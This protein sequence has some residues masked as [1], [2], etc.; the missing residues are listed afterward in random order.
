MATLLGVVTGA[1]PD[2]RGEPVAWV[3]PL[4]DVTDS[5]READPEE[6]PTRGYLFWPQAKDAVRDALVFVRPR[7]NSVHLPGLKDDYMVADPHLAIEVIDFRSM[8]NL[9]D[10]RVALTDGVKLSGVHVV[11]RVLLWCDGNICLGPVRL[12]SGPTGTTLEK[13][14]RHRIPTFRLKPE[15]IKVVKFE[16]ATRYVLSNTTLGGPDGYVDWDDDRQVVKRAIEYSIEVAKRDGAAVDRAKQLVEE[17]LKELQGRTSPADLRLELYRLERATPLL[18]NASHSKEVAAAF[19][20]SLRELPAIKQELDQ[21]K[22]EE[23]ELMRSQIDNAFKTERELLAKVKSER[24]SAES[25]LV[26]T[27]KEIAEREDE[28]KKTAIA[29]DE[30]IRKTIADAVNSAPAIL[31]QVALLKPFLEGGAERNALSEHS[32]ATKRT[33]YQLPWKLGPTPLATVKDLRPRMLNSFK[34]AGILVPTWLRLHAAFAAKLFPVVVGPRAVDALAAYA[35]VA[36][37]GRI[38]VVQ[39]TGAL[40]EPGDIFGRLD[41]STRSFIPHPA[42]LIDI[43]AA[44]REST[45][46]M[47][48]VLDGANRAAT[49]TYLL[50]LV[51]ATQSRTWSIP[52]F[53]PSAVETDDPYRTYARID[54]PKNLLLAGTLVEGPTSLPFAPDLWAQSVLVQTEADSE[55]AGAS[56]NYTEQSE[57]DPASSLLLAGAPTDSASGEWFEGILKIDSARV[58]ARRYQHALKLVQNDSAALQRDLLNA[59]VI[60]SLASIPD[61]ERRS[62]AIVEVKKTLGSKNDTA[63]ADAVET[64]RRRIG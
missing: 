1:K 14:S 51:S 21:A 6:Y 11:G 54:W 39:V 45:G 15:D 7:E 38:A 64:A 25:A 58:V 12:V 16:G 44:A 36:T 26:A 47:L 50:P 24:E 62:A 9:E 10:A 43:V 13:G 17:S 60:P 53:H 29:L 49:E 30:Q 32:R 22:L 4:F 19:L 57:I 46:L 61:D 41:P 59:V 8:H 63:L 3:K 55:S 27:L 5:W 20:S 37:C 33:V 18:E 35:Q 48:V 42:G 40:S 28:A 34:S 31:S 56:Q 52:L 23:R 2:K